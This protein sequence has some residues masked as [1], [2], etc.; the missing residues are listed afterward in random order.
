[1]PRF[2]GNLSIGR[3][4]RHGV[5]LALGLMLLAP[6][7]QA[8]EEA[9]PKLHEVF[10]EDFQMGVSLGHGELESD[11]HQQLLTHFNA[12]TP[13]NDMKW[14][15]IQPTEGN[16]TFEA[17]DALVAYAEREQKRFTAHTLVWHSQTPDWV[18]K[19]ADG[20]PA[21]RELALSRMRTHIREV[22]QRYRGRVDGWD[23]VNE[24]LSDAP[25]EYLRDSPWLRTV[26][27]D[28]VVQA[29]KIAR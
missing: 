5:H 7:V 13:E 1:M 4:T 3:W 10:A 12:I 6:A 11:T 22:M 29:F 19:D 25:K 2:A 27:E 8:Q 16:F 28:Y 26:G 21:S 15:R 24:A 23:V 18:F 14:E 9:L 17:T 20:N